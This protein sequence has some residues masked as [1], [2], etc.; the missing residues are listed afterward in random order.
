LVEIE[1]QSTFIAIKW[2]VIR[3]IAKIERMR[4]MSIKEWDSDPVASFAQ[5]ADDRGYSAKTINVYRSVFLAYVDFIE[6]AGYRLSST[7]ETL[8]SNFMKDRGLRD[9]T[10]KRYLMM[11]SWIF[12]DMFDAK[13]VDDNPATSLLAR[14]RRTRKGKVAKRLPVSLSESEV[15]AFIASL[16]ESPKFFSDMRRKAILLTLL[17]CGLRVQELCNL[18]VAHIHLDDLHP[19]MH[20]IGKGDKER[21]VPIPDSLVPVLIDYRAMLPVTTGYFFGTLRKKFSVP[22]TGSGIYRCVQKALKDAG[23]VK[24]K[25]SPH[26]LRH[27]FATRQLQA[28]KP[29]AVLKAWMGHDQLATTL[30]YEH[31][32]AARTGVRPV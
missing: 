32:T 22:Y 8:L 29:I 10:Q 19:W 9:Q 4:R 1:S 30:I 13:L 16:P 28:G 11:F 14:I 26:I 20:V 12:S 7:T 17:G 23:I 2:L 15:D 31:V 27:T 25:M 5:W 3:R 6:N 24:Q 21:N 18:K